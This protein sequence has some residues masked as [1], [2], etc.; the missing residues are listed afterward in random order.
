MILDLRSGVLPASLEAEFCIIGAGAAGV[1][2]ALELSKAGRSV[3]LIESGGV[4]EEPDTQLLS[5][6]RSI[7]HP[8]AAEHGRFRVLGGS[9]THWSGRCAK[10]DPIDFETR[11]W[12]AHSG[13]PF[14]RKELE[15]FYDDAALYC[16][17]ERGWRDDD[18]RASA[19]SGGSTLF[20][21]ATLEPFVWR[22]APMG[23]VRRVR[24]WGRDF[25]AELRES[26]IRVVLGANLTDFESEGDGQSVQAVIARSLQGHQLKVAARTFVLCCGGLENARLLMNG[27]AR[28]QI[29][30]VS[31]MTGR[32]FMQ[33]PRGD[34][35]QL[36]VD[37]ASSRFLQDHFNVC[38]R[39]NGL[40]YELGFVLPAELQRR[41]QLLNASV[42]LRYT[43]DPQAGWE[44]L[45]RALRTRNLGAVSGALSAPGEIFENL[46][47]RALL[48]H[49]PVLTN[50][51]IW[52]M[53]DLEQAPDPQSRVTLSDDVDALG[54]PRIEIDWRIGALERQTAQHL[55]GRLA[56][57]VARTKL[58][59]YTPAPWIQDGSIPLTGALEGTFH[60]IGLTRMADDPHN[61]VV[62]RSC[63]THGI[64]NLYVQGCSVFPTGGHANPTLTIVA[65]AVRQA[66][67]LTA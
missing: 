1:T 14:E 22:Y 18:A 8:M 55:S 62:D 63:K 56:D 5:L 51:K 25:L 24:D 46:Y 45:K 57:A 12:I 53:I 11:D 16:G 19:L 40:Q 9:T 61:G 13:W 43:P 39:R 31:P 4:K 38:V 54:M 48:G 30:V 33:H 42:I 34:I 17:F 28:G 21:G 35:G 52:A 50:A 66:R 37:A 67:L 47:R 26:P 6:G 15:R 3:V 59:E 23:S 60:H 36:N 20:D 27:K 65:M 64:D 44:H 10:L 2:L 7:G 29:N 49:Q 58:G 41:E 32:C